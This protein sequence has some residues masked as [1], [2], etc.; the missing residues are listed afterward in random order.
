LITINRQS[1]KRSTEEYIL[2][3]LCVLGVL[4]IFPFSV[5]RYMRG[6]W[7]AG[8]IDA[9]LVVGVIVIGLFVW[10]TRRSRLA[11]IILTLFYTCGMVIT[12][13][14]SGVG[15]I[16]WAFP[17]MT[18]AYFL[19]RPNEA[20]IV[21][22]IATVALL[23][24]MLPQIDNI[25][26]YTFLI[27]I[28]LNNLFSY[29]FTSRVQMQHKEL[30]K[31]ATIDSLTGIYN[32]RHFDQRIRESVA[33]RRRHQQ[34]SSL[35]SLDID[36][37]KNVND[38]FGHAKGDEVL[39]F[40]A[41]LLSTQLRASDSVFRIG[42]EEFSILL[43]ATNAADAMILAEDLRVQVEQCEELKKYSLTISLGVAECDQNDT[44]ESWLKKADSALYRAKE[45][46]RNRACLAE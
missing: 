25:I 6:Q 7:L 43:E 2:L 26:F 15:L 31:L 19:I 44:A 21:N 30:S 12:V 32:R 41:G 29:T 27:T 46:G 22:T 37:F 20:A 9:V 24:V 39:I 11:S 4:G 10:K 8:T 40:L 45:S 28:V 38:T 13:Y 16:Y 17:T 3:A 14:V 34:V 1:V 35:I 5:V 36:H 23:P 42:G 18:A 33:L